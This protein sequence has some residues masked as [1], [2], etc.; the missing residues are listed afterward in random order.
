M[1]K[2][3]GEAETL[4]KSLVSGLGNQ[5]KVEVVLCPPFTAVETVGRVISGTQIALGAQDVFYVPEGAYTGEVSCTM[6]LDLGCRYVIIGHSE[7]RQHFG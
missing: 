3:R 4:A 5:E 1:H 7:R 6:L 2:T